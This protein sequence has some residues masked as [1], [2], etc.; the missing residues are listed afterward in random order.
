[1]PQTIEPIVQVKIC[2]RCHREKSL[3]MFPLCA[4]KRNGHSSWCKDC[5]NEDARSFY[6][7]H[8]EQKSAKQKAYYATHP[9]AER[10]AAK[11]R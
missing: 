11:K 4:T 1:V 5:K 6:Q 2:T 9:E 3:E 10:M 8:R 7:N